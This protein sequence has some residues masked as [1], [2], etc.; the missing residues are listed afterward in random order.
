MSF[1][2]TVGLEYGDEKNTSSNDRGRA[3]G[4]RG[5]LP[6]GRVFR[7]ALAD[8]GG[9]LTAGDLVQ[10]PVANGGHHDTGLTISTSI[11]DYASA[12]SGVSSAGTTVGIIMATTPPAARDQF[13]DGYMNVET[14]PG[15]GVY[16]ITGNGTATS[17]HGAL[18]T[19]HESDE[20][21]VALT[22]VSKI[23]L[24]PSPYSSV[25]QNPAG[26]THAPLGVVPGMDG[27]A[28]SSALYFWVQT[29]GPASVAYNAGTAA[30]V[31][32]APA[33]ADNSVAGAITGLTSVSSTVQSQF[34]ATQPPVGIVYGGVP[35]DTDKILVD[36]HLAN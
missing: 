2:V 29:W 9:S 11:G 7:W 24:Q 13:A 10:A 28:V 16:R 12:D 20:L 1:P 26:Q 33:Y 21:K 18:F 17:G 25:I 30:L 34:A 8:A 27:D 32:G 35:D 14:T 31:A 3:L 22:T 23:G 36:L 6:D 15:A 19:L 5:I 4:T